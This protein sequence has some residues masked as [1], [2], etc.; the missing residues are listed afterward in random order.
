MQ[1]VSGGQ[2]LVYNAGFIVFPDECAKVP[3]PVCSFRLAVG[4]RANKPQQFVPQTGGWWSG[5]TTPFCETACVKVFLF[6]GPDRPFNSNLFAN[7]TSDGPA[8]FCCFIC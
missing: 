3:S 7:V 5:V 4:F 2:D 8:K 1:L 6:K